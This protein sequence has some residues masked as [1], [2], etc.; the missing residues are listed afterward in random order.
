MSF[1]PAW[2][3]TLWIEAGSDCSREGSLSRMSGTVA[4]GKQCVAALK[5]RVFLIMESPTISVVGGNRG[6]GGVGSD[7]DLVEDG[8]GADDAE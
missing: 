8:H 1:I 5:K 4:P 3:I 7:S 6:R 2:T